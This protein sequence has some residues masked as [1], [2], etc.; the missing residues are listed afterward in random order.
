M[1]GGDIST[2]EICFRN[3]LEVAVGFYLFI[4]DHASLNV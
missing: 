2:L 3:A 1:C 4:L